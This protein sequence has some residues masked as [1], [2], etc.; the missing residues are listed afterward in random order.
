MK[1]QLAGL[2]AAA[3]LAGC[4]SD[5]T[6]ADHPTPTTPT[7]PIGRDSRPHWPSE[8]CGTRSGSAIDYVADAVGAD[9]PAQALATYNP[10]GLSVV[11]EEAAAAPPGPLAGRGRGQRDRARSLDVRGRPRL[12]GR[13]R[14]GVQRLN[15]AAGD[16]GWAG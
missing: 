2:A 8:G 14:R 13:R 11:R 15:R 4:G 6:V 7:A 9:T 1:A 12:A 3:L 5:A 16:R 10:D